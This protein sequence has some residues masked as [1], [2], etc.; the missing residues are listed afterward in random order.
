MPDL[1]NIAEAHESLRNLIHDQVTKLLLANSQLT[2][3]QLETLLAD[4][5]A[6]G[7]EVKRTRKRFYRPIGAKI[8]RGSYNRTL[9]QAQN[10]VIRSIYTVLLLGYLGLFDTA[11]LQPFIELADTIESYV[12]DTKVN[13]S[14]HDSTKN[15]E[16]RLQE[17]I[18]A[19]AKRNSFKD[20]L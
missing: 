7:E 6:T 10:N 20:I 1:S 17:F 2:L 15:L 3:T 19:L 8:T 14:N 4:S 18:S 16:E 12:E 9:I 11:S 13:K 5:I